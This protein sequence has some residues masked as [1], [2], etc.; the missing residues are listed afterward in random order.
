MQ[1]C[2]DTRVCF[3]LHV[4]CLTSS[5]FKTLTPTGSHHKTF[6]EE[7]VTNMPDQDLHSIP[8]ATCSDYVIV[9][10]CVVEPFLPNRLVTAIELDLII[11][12]IR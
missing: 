9:L 11:A 1:P 5:H 6:I 12:L 4:R 3:I 2:T 8:F 7:F 10:Q